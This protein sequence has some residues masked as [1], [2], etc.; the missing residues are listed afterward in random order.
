M[1]AIYFIR[2]DRPGFGAY[3]WTTYGYW[4]PEIMIAARFGKREAQALVTQLR[5]AGY[6]ARVVN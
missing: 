3:Y 1:K 6:D 4:T 2:E 5:I